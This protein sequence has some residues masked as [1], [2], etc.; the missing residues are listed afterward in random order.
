MAKAESVDQNGDVFHQVLDLGS[1]LRSGSSN[2]NNFSR[3]AATLSLV[4]PYF[5]G[6]FCILVFSPAVLTAVL[7]LYV[8]TQSFYHR[9]TCL[10]VTRFLIISLC[11]CTIFTV[12]FCHGLCQAFLDGPRRN[13]Y[14]GHGTGGGRGKRYDCTGI[15]QNTIDTGSQS[16]GFHR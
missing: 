3:R 11:A 14:L 15:S 9:L 12:F 13:I 1:G 10:Y 7:P 6:A 4:P 2:E 8:H 16:R 5:P